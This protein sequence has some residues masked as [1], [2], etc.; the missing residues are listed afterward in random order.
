MNQRLNEHSKY[1]QNEEQKLAQAKIIHGSNTHRLSS[2]CQDYMN[3]LL[4]SE[5]EVVG[6]AQ[7]GL[8]RIS[9]TMAPDM[10]SSYASASVVPTLPW[11]PHL[12]STLINASPMTA[13][14]S[15]HISTNSGSSSDNSPSYMPALYQIPRTINTVSNSCADV[16]ETSE[17]S[18]SQ[19]QGSSDRSRGKSIKRK[20]ADW[21]N[22]H[23]NLA[24]IDS[25]KTHFH[26][27]KK[28]SGKMKS[29]LWLKIHTR[30]QDLCRE[31]NVKS[32]SKD[33]AQIKSR[34][35]NLEYEFKQVK[36]RMNQTGEE[37]AEKIKKDCSYYEELNS[38]LGNRD[39]INLDRMNI[40]STEIK[41]ALSE[42]AEDEPDSPA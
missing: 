22:Q 12:S 1:Y 16:S 36:M 28:A 20:K 6:A 9:G 34:V 10:R 19:E 38:F 11:N 32:D 40:T 27:L 25:W 23:E 37:G 15:Y 30:F 2:E 35:K 7:S 31:R 33:L 21:E 41:T 18:G 5:P 13:A 29:R 26:A 3:L 4:G 8:E 39:A 17:S 42:S 14:A 24:L